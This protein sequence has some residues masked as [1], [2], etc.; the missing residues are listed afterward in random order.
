MAFR[1]SSGTAAELNGRAVRVDVASL[2]IVSGST[3]G[4]GP[5]GP[6][7]VDFLQ[8]TLDPIALL[9]RFV[10]EELELRDALQPEPVAN[11]PPQERRRAL[12]RPARFAARLV[13]A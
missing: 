8:D 3:V 13:V 6:L 10:E 2:L 4:V 5:R 1:M 12:Q 7:G 9:D 11:L